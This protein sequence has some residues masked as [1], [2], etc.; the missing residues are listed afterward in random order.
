MKH[1]IYFISFCLI[2]AC[3]FGR[4]KKLDLTAAYISLG[5]DIFQID[6]TNFNLEHSTYY[7][8]EALKCIA[9]Q[10]FSD[11]WVFVNGKDLGTWELP[12]EI[13][14]LAS[15]KTNVIIYPGIKMNGSSTSR[16]RYPFV[17]GGKLLLDLKPGETTPIEKIPIKYYISTQ[18]DDVLETFESIANQYFEAIDSTG[19][20]FQRV[21]DSYDPTNHHQVGVLT[22]GA[23]DS[24]FNIQSH[25]L[26][27]NRLP[28]A[29]FLEMDFRCDAATT[30]TFNVG[31]FIEKSITSIISY[32]PLVV[33][34]ASNEWKKIYINLTQ[35]VLRNNTYATAYRVFLSGEYEGSTPINLYFDNIKVVYL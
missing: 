2:L 5:K 4:C 27:F 17:D 29:V 23:G 28:E 1:R 15:G 12:C 6:M 7:D 20:N 26:T 21:M 11:A 10:N 31:M 35:S 22:L 19:I 34:N 33:V 13:P 14:I 8:E 32:E 16:P 24:I 25:N 3:L 18:F 9:S 30:Q